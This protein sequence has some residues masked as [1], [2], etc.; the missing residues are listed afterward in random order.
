MTYLRTFNN[1]ISKI[2]NKI[3][4]YQE[5]KKV[6]TKKEVEDFIYFLINSNWDEFEKIYFKKNLDQIYK[7]KFDMLNFSPL[8]LTLIIFFIVSLIFL[9]KVTSK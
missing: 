7:E 1:L 3:N 9:L 8:T 2:H 4:N 6:I 5:E